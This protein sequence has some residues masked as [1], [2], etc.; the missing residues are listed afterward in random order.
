MRWGIEKS[1]KQKLEKTADRSEYASDRKMMFEGAEKKTDRTLIDATE[2]NGFVGI[3]PEEKI[4]RDQEYVQ[5]KEKEFSEKILN[6]EDEKKIKLAKIFEAIIYQMGELG[7]WFGESGMIIKSTRYDDIKNG[8]DLIIEFPKEEDGEEPYLALA[9]DVT[10]SSYED[11]YKKLERIKDGIERGELAKIEYFKSEHT[12]FKGGI[13]DI[14][15]TVI[16]TDTKILYEVMDL[17]V[18]EKERE[19]EEH[20]IQF[21]ILDQIM[22][23]LVKF[24][25]YAESV[26]KPEIAKKYNKAI[27]IME[28]VLDE[29]QDLREEVLG[30]DNL[31]IKGDRVHQGISSYLE[32][33]KPQKGPRVWKY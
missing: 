10:F 12:K 31:I 21:M 2:I 20:P 7:N 16:G 17:W 14:P 29:K 9:V 23:Q 13:N 24:K 27:K 11:L 4:K 8:V 28:R 19:L 18:N 1:P 33:L 15:K 32:R 3:Y 30:G 22:M 5:K 6:P 26:K 25:E